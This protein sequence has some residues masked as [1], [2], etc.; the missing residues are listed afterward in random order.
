M[1]V[2]CKI[3]ALS[4]IVGLLLVPMA[5]HAAGKQ[6]KNR[7]TVPYTGV[8]QDEN[9]SP[10]GGV[11]PMRFSFYKARTSKRAVWSEEHWV[12]VDAGKYRVELGAQK[13]IPSK[14]K[15]EEVFVGIVLK[16][17]GEILRER[18]LASVQPVSPP[19]LVQK[20]TAK[21]SSPSSTLGPGVVERAMHAYEAEHAINADKLNHQTLEDIKKQLVIPVRIGKSTKTT[22]SVG[23]GRGQPF[24]ESCPEG[25]VATGFKGAAGRYVDSLSLICSPLR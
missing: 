22:G 6:T 19:S 7:T 25:Y 11:Y 24:E 14:L 16:G 5:T 21:A 10:V 3:T 15:L 8:L 18:L 12:A 20:P 13:K 17:A 1:N 9:L 4:V 23:G 2:E